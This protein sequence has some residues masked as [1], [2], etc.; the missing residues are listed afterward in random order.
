MFRHRIHTYSF[1]DS[2]QVSIL[3]GGEILCLILPSSAPGE[4]PPPPP[5]AF[6]GRNELIDKIVHFAER[7]SPVALIGAG[8]IGKTSIVLTVLHDDRIRQRFGDNRRFIRC[9][10]FPASRAHFLRQISK[11]VGAGIEN[12]EDLTP[13]RQ[14]LSSKEMLI[15]LDNAESIL[16]SQESSGQEIYTIVD[17]LNQF[18]NICLCITSRISIIPPHCEVLY[19]P[20]LSMEAGRDTFYRIYKHSEQSDLVNDILKQL[21]FHPL[22]VTLLATVAQRNTWDAKR[23]SREWGRQRTGVLRSQHSRSLAATIELSLASPMFQELGPGA[24]GFLEVVAF[25]PQGVSEENIDWLFPA[26]FDGPNMFDTFCVLSLTHRSNGFIT[27]LAPLRDY[28]RPKDPTSSALLSTTRERYFSR[29]STHVH[30]NKPNFQESRWITSE[31]VNVEYLLDVFTSID[32]NPGDVWDWD[33]CGRFMNHLYWHKP[34]LIMLGPKI[35]ALPD[36]HPSKPQCLYDLSR[37]FS[38]AGNWSEYKRLLTHTLKLWR[39]RGD[40]DQVAQRLRDLSEANRLMRLYEEGIQ[41][42]KEASEIFERL[43][44][45]VKQAG[46]L[47]YL[48][49]VLHD[50]EQLDAAQEAAYRAIDLLPEEGE[51]FMV[52]Q[53]HRILGET[54]DLKGDTEKAIH[55]FEVAL[56]IASSLNLDHQLFW[57]HYSLAQL[58]IFSGEGRFDDAQAHIERAKSHVINDVFK[59]GRA[60]ELQAKSLYQQHMYEKA[61]PEALHAAD[62]FEKLGA[63]QDLEAC[64]ELLQWIDEELDSRASSDESDV[65]GESPETLPLPVRINVLFQGQE[66]E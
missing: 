15:V 54:Y 1:L 52:C 40:D 50:D 51:Q 53:G 41:R 27:M 30:P 36:D 7:L 65:Y 38:S 2:K 22:S 5:R 44:D 14:Y 48:A 26:I 21:D 28:L 45:T 11:V 57:V 49:H 66:T 58:F 43:G 37:L 55:H 17:E 25:F 16:D 33:V 56:E 39:E 13:L 24:R 18:S 63:A 64:R 9:D 6:F 61:K 29:L 12:P 31:D 42:A 4:L 35:E 8:G 32:A 20:T 59:L 3:G 46:C 23:L 34:R 47:V 10:H 62:V 19:I 60:M